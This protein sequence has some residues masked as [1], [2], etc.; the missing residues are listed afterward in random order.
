MKEN[1]HSPVIFASEESGKQSLSSGHN[2]NLESAKYKVKV[3]ITTP[4]RLVS[5]F[6]S[7]LTKLSN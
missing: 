5:V 3:I 1:G 2:L 6:L 4:R 7:V